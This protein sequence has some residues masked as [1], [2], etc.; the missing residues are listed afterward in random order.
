MKFTM[1]MEADNLEEMLAI[2]KIM[3]KKCE[4]YNG[5]R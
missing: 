5:R 3:N 2:G 1:S 4:R